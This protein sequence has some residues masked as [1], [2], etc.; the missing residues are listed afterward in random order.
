MISTYR[1]RTLLAGVFLLLVLW[2]AAA[3]AVPKTDVITLV[4]GDIITCEIKEMVRGKLRAKTD[5]MGTV[6][7]EWDKITDIVSNYWFRISLRNGSLVYGQMSDSAESGQMVIDFQTR[8]T[9]IAMDQVV[10]IEPVRFDLWDRFDMSASFGFNWNKGSQVLQSNL[11]ANVKYRGAI[12][13]YGFDLTAM[14]TDRGEGEITRRNEIGLWLARQVSGKFY[15]NLDVGTQRN[16]E[17]GLRRRVSGGLNLGYFLLRSNHLE[18]V[19]LAGA[20]VNREWATEESDPSNNAE[21]RLGTQFQL[22]YYDTPKS[23]I[24][25][26]ADVYPNFTVK[27]RW[28]F[29]GSISGRQEIISDLFIKVE[30]YESRDN[31]PPSGASAKSDRG[32]ILSIEWTK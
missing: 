12:Y 20:T 13:S 6:T 15:S 23:D 17:L 18:F 22:F 24:S 8:S 19:T 11:G 2:P 32:I 16:D 14:V 28:R 29:E 31:K 9:T 3:A 26:Q 4:N 30:Y 5:H 21:G 25:I 1:I 10:E 27:G 7:I